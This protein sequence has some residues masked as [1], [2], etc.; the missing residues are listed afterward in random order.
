LTPRA[1]S[2]ADQIFNLNQNVLL[3]GPTQQERDL[4]AGWYASGTHTLDKGYVSPGWQGRPGGPDTYLKVYA[5]SCRGCHI[6]MPD[7]YNFEVTGFT[8]TNAGPTACAYSPGSLMAFPELNRW[9]SM[10]NSLITFNR[11][12]GS[13]GTAEDQPAILNDYLGGP[14]YQLTCRRLPH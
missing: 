3:A 7:R 2:Q 14:T 9:N 12:W 8:T 6:A 11:F 13:Q 4:I 1:R 5:H 10:P